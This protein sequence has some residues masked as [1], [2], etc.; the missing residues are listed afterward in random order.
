[1][2][3]RVPDC[4]THAPLRLVAALGVLAL[5]FVASIPA[6]Q[7]AGT[8]IFEDFSN[9]P[10]VPVTG[11]IG[12]G[13]EDSPF[14]YTVT[15]DCRAIASSNQTAT[16]TQ[17]E[18][19]K[20]YSFRLLLML[21]APG[22]FPAAGEYC[23]WRT[24]TVTSNATISG[25]LYEFRDDGALLIDGVVDQLPGTN[26]SPPFGGQFVGLAAA[27]FSTGVESFGIDFLTGTV[28]GGVKSAPIMTSLLIVGPPS[29]PK[30]GADAR[31]VV[32]IVDSTVATAVEQ[33]TAA[34]VAGTSSG[35]LVRGG[36]VVPMLSALDLSI[37]PRGGVLLEAEGFTASVSSDVG[38]RA[39]S[40]V[41]VQESGAIQCLLCSDFTPGSVVEGW[42]NSDPRLAAAVQI[43]MDAEAGDCHLLE[44][45]T[46]SPLD[47]GGAIEAGA[48]TLQVRMYLQ[49]GFAVLSTGIT[50]GNITPARVPA[51]EGPTVPGW[52]LAL[53]LLAAAGAALAVRR[54]VVTG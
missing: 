33:S 27:Q 41:V 44:I 43:P 20:Y 4:T 49:D 26:Y 18:P 36:E 9:L 5:L 8:P 50:I 29:Q 32:S 17:A 15:L 48:H 3:S 7:A 54:Q 16:V 24:V 34:G 47:G 31:A 10:G 45:P 23:D 19:G 53:T 2:R 14:V 51:G 6:P 37:G 30:Q 12:D 52:L 42:V 22:P 28:T 39:D 35:V 40:G 13:S 25:S 21:P 11:P 46:G 38:A 1:M